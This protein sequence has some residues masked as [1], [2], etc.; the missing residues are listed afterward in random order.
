M[1]FLIATEVT[2]NPQCIVCSPNTGK[3]VC[4]A[5][6]IFVAL[7]RLSTINGGLTSFH[8]KYHCGVESGFEGNIV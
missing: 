1:C 3:G 6:N 7:E 5:N 2:N 4:L 8:I